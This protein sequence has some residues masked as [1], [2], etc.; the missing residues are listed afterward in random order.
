[1]AQPAPAAPAAP[2][3]AP[4]PAAPVPA[5]VT[6]LTTEPLFFGPNIPGMPGQPSADCATTAEEFFT[7]MDRIRLQHHPNDDAAAIARAVANLRGTAASWWTTID[8]PNSGQDPDLTRNWAVFAR[9]F[10]T[11]WF[12]SRSRWD[13]A[14]N[15]LELVQHPNEPT[16]HFLMRIH[17]QYVLDQNL[18]IDHFDDFLNNFTPRY[19]AAQAAVMAALPADVQVIAR[20]G[21]LNAA[22]DGLNHHLRSTLDVDITRALA[23]TCRSDQLRKAIRRRATT[24]ITVAALSEFV[25]AEEASM[26]IRRISANDTTRTNGSNGNNGNHRRQANGTNGSN[27]NNGNRRPVGALTNA[28]RRTRISEVADARP[29]HDDD[30]DYDDHHHVDAIHRRR[31]QR[32]RPRR[33]QSPRRRRRYEDEPPEWNPPRR[34][35]QGRFR[36]R[37]P[38][39]AASAASI[40]TTCYAPD[41]DAGSCPV[42]ATAAAIYANEDDYP[43]AN[44]DTYDTT[45]QGN[46]Y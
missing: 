16:W 22:I 23:L 15:H 35:P 3:P 8:R 12:A 38:P 32:G 5:A 4:A 18:Q 7:R 26:T 10:R 42:S 29:H 14:T 41:H 46:D 30:D 13:T 20:Q 24:G 39:T 9:T 40:C 17:H 21:A 28:L 2:A 27:G 34:D 25:R 33:Q 36:P 6:A 31:G 1:M 19:T 11:A 37:A 43:E 45:D 44:Y